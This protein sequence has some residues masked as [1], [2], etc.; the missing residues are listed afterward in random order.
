[1]NHNLQPYF[2]TSQI[3]GLYHQSSADLMSLLLVWGSAELFAL[4]PQLH[5]VL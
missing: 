3:H 5:R 4:Q 2:I 1:M